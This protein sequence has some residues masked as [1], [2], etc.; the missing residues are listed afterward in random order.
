VL[1]KRIEVKKHGF[2]MGCIPILV[3]I[4]ASDF[5]KS[6]SFQKSKRSLKFQGRIIIFILLTHGKGDLKYIFHAVQQAPIK[7]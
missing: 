4:P 5:Y 1:L 7:R 6:E 2:F 3:N